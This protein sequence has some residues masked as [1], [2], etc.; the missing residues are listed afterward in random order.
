M[1]FF[2]GIMLQSITR[3]LGFWFSILMV[4]VILAGLFVLPVF[5]YF[6]KDLPDYNQLAEY[7]PPTISRVYSGDGEL[8]VELAKERRIFRKIEEIPQLVVDAFLAAEDQNYYDHPGIDVTSILRAAFQNASNVGSD[9]NPVGGSTITQQVVKNFLLTNERSFS[10]KIKEAILAYRINKVYTKDRILELYLNQIYLGNGSY[11]VTSAALNYFNKDLDDVTLEEAALLAALPKAPSLLDP[12]RNPEKARMRRDWV[13]ERM[14]EENFIKQT[15]AKKAKAT[16]IKLTPRY[17]HSILDSGYYTES[18]RLMLIDMYGEDKVY[19]EGI[20]AHTNLDKNLQKYADE[21]LRTGL[22]DYDRRHG[23]KGA[24]TNLKFK[25][26]EWKKAIK[27]FEPEPASSTAGWKSA[28]VISVAPEQ[29]QIGLKD[30]SKSYIPLSKLTWAR[31][32][33][34]KQYVGKKI[35]SAKDVLKQGDVIYVSADPEGKGNSL[36]Q[37]P[38]A[39]G[40]LVAIQPK[41]GKV[42]AMAGGFSFKE[43]KYNRAI[44]A[45]RQPGS[46]FKPFVYL[47][48]LEKGFSPNSIVKDEPISI[49]QGPGMPAWTPKNFEGKFLGEITLR[50]ALEKSRN[51]ATVHLLTAVG[52]D[53][54]REVSTRLKIYDN[55]PKIYSMALGSHESTLMQMTAAYASFASGGMKIEPKLIDRVQDRKGRMIFGTEMRQCNGCS[56]ETENANLKT[57]EIPNLKYTTSYVIEPAVN[58]QMVSILQGVVER[59]TAVRAKQIGK[60]LAG[61]TGTSN[62]SNDTWFIGFSPDL[63]CGIYIGYDQPKSLGSKESGATLPLPIFVK[64]MTNAIADMPNREFEVPAGIEFVKIDH[65]TGKTPGVFTSEKTI[66]SEPMRQSDMEIFKTLSSDGQPTDEQQ[67][68]ELGNVEPSNPVDSQP[69]VSG[70]Y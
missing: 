10:R 62:D 44:Q 25:G 31:K 66:V 60:V 5:M 38:D 50:Q 12:T 39:N 61:K 13:L 22:I 14:F 68:P 8:M 23:F 35:E 34:D 2:K 21:A 6:S 40:A 57:Y 43:S 17:E 20:S 55:P 58:Y 3:T 48:A 26:D 53:R 29:A 7:D 63:V 54:V 51:L 65:K 27:D 42:L 4:G 67:N 24:V 9:K 45:V 59:G 30:G 36:E 19:Q 56:S 1:E 33:L 32:R 16:P 28:I 64:F 52:L 11:G 69:A 46:T 70:V 18:V 47:A 37:I 41:T 49:S 15:Q